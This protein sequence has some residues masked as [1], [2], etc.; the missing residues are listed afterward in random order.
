MISQCSIKDFPRFDESADPVIG[1]LADH[2][3]CKKIVAESFAKVLCAVR[4]KARCA[5]ID[6]FFK[7][8]QAGSMLAEHGLQIRRGV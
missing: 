3:D 4:K 8:Q 2:R 1:H 7:A 5:I 6:G